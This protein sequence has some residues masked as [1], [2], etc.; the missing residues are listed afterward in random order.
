MAQSPSRTCIRPPHLLRGSIPLPVCG[1][2]EGNK[3]AIRWKPLERV[4]LYPILRSMEKRGLRKKEGSMK[5]WSR[6]PK[7][8]SPYTELR[9]PVSQRMC[10]QNRANYDPPQACMATQCNNVTNVKETEGSSHGKQ[11]NRWLKW[12]WGDRGGLVKSWQGRHKK[13]RQLCKHGW[14]CF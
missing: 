6:H 14:C 4:S 1:E 3:K 11:L 2:T 10:K 7:S 8:V 13:C 5:S 12:G 9:V